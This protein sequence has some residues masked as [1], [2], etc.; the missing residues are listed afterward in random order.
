MFF[1]MMKKFPSF[2]LLNI[3]IS[4]RIGEARLRQPLCDHEDSWLMTPMDP[5]GGRTE[6]G[7]KVGPED[8]ALL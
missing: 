7:S 8:V 2:L 1:K 3:A 5:F 4:M 6:R